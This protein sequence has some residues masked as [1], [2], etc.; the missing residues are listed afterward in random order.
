M[1]KIDYFIGGV[2]VGTLVTSLIVL[3]SWL[4]A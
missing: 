3:G 2:L 1:D 4:I